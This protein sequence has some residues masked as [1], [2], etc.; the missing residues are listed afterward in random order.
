MGATA[1]LGAFFGQG[2]GGLEKNKDKAYNFTR[3]AA[4]GGYTKAMKNLSNCYLH[5]FGTD[6]NEVLAQQWLDAYNAVCPASIGPAPSS[7]CA[8]TSTTPHI[9]EALTTHTPSANSGLGQTSCVFTP[10]ADP[11]SSER[12]PLQ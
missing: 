4:E 2:R 10:S 6:K 11:V 5:G 8:D 9:S 1:A 12:A 3:I 7:T